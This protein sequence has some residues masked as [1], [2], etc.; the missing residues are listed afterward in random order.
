LSGLDAEGNQFISLGSTNETLKALLGEV[1]RV[2]APFLIANASAVQDG[3]ESFQ[4]TI[5]NKPWRQP[6]FPYQAKC[7]EWLRGGYGG[8]SG[9]SKSQVDE[10]LQN[11]GCEQ[12]F[13]S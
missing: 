2:Y 3:A 8:L 1:G 7:L 6:T 4:T 5:D 13:N 11:T 10:L 12:L 9:E